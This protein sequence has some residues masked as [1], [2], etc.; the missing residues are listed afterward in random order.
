[1]KSDYYHAFRPG[2][3]PRLA[4]TSWH[5]PEQAQ[6]AAGARCTAVARVDMGSELRRDP[7]AFS[8]IEHLMPGR[9][10]A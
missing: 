2:D 9:R 1:M 10:G 8:L 5:E 3:D 6:A 7:A 4:H